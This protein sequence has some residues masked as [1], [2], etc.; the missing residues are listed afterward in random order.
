MHCTISDWELPMTACR[1]VWMTLCCTGGGIAISLAITITGKIPP[2]PPPAVLNSSASTFISHHNRL[3]GIINRVGSTV[4]W[5]DLASSL[6]LCLSQLL[7]FLLEV[8]SVPLS[9]RPLSFVCLGLCLCVCEHSRSIR[10]LMP[11]INGSIDGLPLFH[12]FS[13]FFWSYSYFHSLL[14]S[15][16]MRSSDGDHADSITNIINIKAPLICAQ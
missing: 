2:L 3:G 8:F 6:S 7:P 12:S 16:V 9:S 5:H 10:W 14:L 4:A 11:V 13:L 1:P 15:N